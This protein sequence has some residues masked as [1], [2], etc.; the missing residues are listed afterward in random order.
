MNNRFLSAIFVSLA[1]LALS[2]CAPRE[3]AFQDFGPVEQDFVYDSLALSPVAATAA[4]YHQHNGVSLDGLLD[5]YSP[6]GVDA[7]RQFLTGFRKRLETSIHRDELVPESQVDYDII[8]DQISAGLLD[9]DTIQSYRHNPT[10]YVELIGNGLFTPY[11][12]SYAPLETRYRHIVSRLNRIPAFLE[13]AKKNLVNSPAVW[14][15][16]AQ[17]ENDGNISLI[18]KTLRNDAPDEVKADYNASADTALKAL[19]N[20]NDYLKTDLD[21]RTCDWRLGKEKYD[22]K[23]RYTLEINKTPDQVLRDAEAAL[24]QIRAE[25]AEL[26]KPLTVEAA[27]DKIA[28]KHA[29]PETYMQAARRDLA[30]TTAFVQKKKLLALPSGENLQV[31][32]T[33][34]FMRGIYTVGGFNGA[35][36][37]EP[38]LG[39]F[40]W[41]TPI[42]T[43]WPKERIESKLREY[44]FYGLKTL[45][46]HEAMPGHYVQ[47]EYANRVEPKPRRILRA[48]YSNTPY[49]EGWAVYATQLM[50]DQGYMNGDKGMRLTFLK[51]MLRVLANAIIDI[52]FHTMGMT[53]QQAMDLMTDK[54]YQEKEEAT[55]KLQRAEL[56]S[57][58]L[59][60]YFV[61]WRGW[62]EVRDAYSKSKG[63]A[64][65]LSDFHEAALKE[66]AVPLPLLSR[67]LTGK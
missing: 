18:D 52:R 46:I 11:V 44:N 43:N 10:V 36:P 25:M 61:G 20:F 26:A 13:Q 6:S 63:G 12:L 47:L 28:Q 62:L 58:Q 2:D 40:F 53:E 34:V 22:Q 23:F 21:K 9:L 42:P 30:E 33:P 7:Q 59:P 45:V 55:E 48:V 19:R 65:Q 64:F 37:L 14:T 4:G 41:I 39:A 49:V 67:L 27:L 32:D 5:D 57:C 24:Q 17:E 66:G 15:R 31:I 3:K 38:Q 8:Q 16:V 29:T 60:T 1:L 35:P 50:I 56:S 51:Q 54:T